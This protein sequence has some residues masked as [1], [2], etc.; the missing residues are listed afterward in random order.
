M[1]NGTP[2]SVIRAEPRAAPALAYNR[3]T[4]TSSGPTPSRKLGTWMCTA[5]VVG[6]MVG[7]GIFLLPASLAPYGSYSILGWLLT[8]AGSMLVALV[9]A[10]LSRKLP[11]AGGPYAFT[12]RG[13]GDFAGFLIAWG[14]WISMLAT[15]GAIAVAFVSY[16]TAFWPVLGEQPVMALIVALV[17]VWTLTGVNIAGIRQGGRVQVVTT[18]L[19]LVPLAVMGTLGFVYFDPQNL[20]AGTESVAPASAVTASVTLTLWAF[21]GLESATIPADS[22]HEPA[23]TIPRATLL[24]TAI[25][26]VAYLASTTAVMGILPAPDLASSTAPFADA[27]RGVWGPT[28]AAMMA[29]GA[30]VSCLGALNGWILLQAQI[31]LAIARDGLFPRFFARVSANGTP[32]T[33]LVVSSVLVSALLVLNFT[34]GLVELFTFAILLAT[35][36]A[37]IPYAFCTVT[38][39]L[40]VGDERQRTGRRLAGETIVAFLAFAYS[41]WAIAGSGRKTRSTGA[42]SC[43]SWA[44]R[45]TP[46]SSARKSRREKGD[47]PLF[48]RPGHNRTLAGV[49]EGTVPFFSSTGRAPCSV[50]G[51]RRRRLR[52][53][54]HRRG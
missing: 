2:R 8:G 37:V 39:L 43:S 32:V 15:N 29:I 20:G 21:L 44:S 19:K 7:S 5:L 46:G 50:A 40:L 13:F 25:A 42:S 41:V 4:L 6:N 24:G 53:H 18:V 45:S 34:K 54:R 22:V 10:R 30:V 23:R 17:T 12:R 38:E 47:C 14:Y 11:S 16:L 35:L 1:I 48:F 33:G 51:C 52:G 3:R 26:G 36:T 28:A 9:F 27:A 49:K 31:P